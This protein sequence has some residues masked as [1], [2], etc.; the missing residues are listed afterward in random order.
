MA[1]NCDISDGRL[2]D[3]CSQERAGVKTVFFYR[4]SELDLTYDSGGKIT[5]IGSGTL[6]RFEQGDAH[7]M[8][9]QTITRGD[10][11][12]TYMEYQ[13]D[14]TTF[15]LLAS[16]LEVINALKAGSWAIFWLDN[17][18][19]IRLFGAQTPMY[20]QQG[21]TQSGQGPGD[22]TY[23]NLSFVGQGQDYAP[24][25]EEF[26]EFPFDNFPNSVVPPYD[27]GDDYLLINDTDKLLANSTDIILIKN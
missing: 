2:L 11:D 5:G 24:F 22:T 3:D 10:G 18:D 15:H 19:N 12:T 20:N 21:V 1:L 6:Y 9:F 7:G 14:M 4:H 25:V 17:A 27:T 26:T 23:T 8:A 13:I 16:F